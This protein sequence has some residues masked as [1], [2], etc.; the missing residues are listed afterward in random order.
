MSGRLQQWWQQ[1]SLRDSA[2]LVGGGIICACLWIFIAV[3]DEVR[4]GD[5]QP[6]EERIILALR[7]PGDPGH[8]RGPG[9][10]EEAARDISA[11]G[12]V[13]VLTLL[14]ATTTG[15]LLLSGRGRL[16]LV[17]VIAVGG[18]TILE[19]AL[20]TAFARA[21]PEE[22]LR[23]VQVTSFSF[24]SGHSMLSSVVYLT[25]GALL[26]RTVP[27]PAQKSFIIGAALGLSF[28]VGLSRVMLGVHYPTDVVAGWTLGIAWSLL[29]GLAA[30]RL[31]KAKSPIRE[32]RAGT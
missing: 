2:L 5:F 21:R 23:L 19:S 30:S 28:L 25:L 10:L 27:R 26:A 6:V 7:R 12:G 9:W 17:I 20:K 16:A 14:T 31:Q 15:Y 18:G 22:S 3:A 8:L 1:S 4:E 11:L 24:P 29:C 32:D 13:T